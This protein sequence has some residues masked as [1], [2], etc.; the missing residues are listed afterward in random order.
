MSVWCLVSKEL[1]LV[2]IKQ[3][4]TE[5]SSLKVTVSLHTNRN[6]QVSSI[7]VYILYLGVLSPLLP[8]D[9]EADIKDPTA[10]SPWISPFGDEAA[11]AGLRETQTQREKGGDVLIT[12]GM[13]CIG[14]QRT[15]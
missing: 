3:H 15:D 6:T 8:H 14:F 12:R 5:S 2:K 11:E 1:P 9:N 4:G 7:P 10:L 13:A